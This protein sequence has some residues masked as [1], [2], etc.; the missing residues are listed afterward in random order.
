MI[1]YKEMDWKNVKGLSCNYCNISSCE[2]S[3]MYTPVSKFDVVQKKAQLD[4][5]EWSN[6]DKIYYIKK[7]NYG[8]CIYFDSYIKECIL[9]IERRFNSCLLFPVRVYYSNYKI[10]LILNIN[11]PSSLTLFD[12]VARREP[13]VCRFVKNAAKIFSEDKEYSL[14][15]LN[16]TKDFDKVLLI[17]NLSDWREY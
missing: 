7:D 5:L 1:N 12:Y 11:C 4:N 14:H 8:K 2:N 16:K 3:I 13:S 6:E 10:K 15:V 17:G 9:P